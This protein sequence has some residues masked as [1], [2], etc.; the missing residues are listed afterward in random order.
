MPKTANPGRVA[1]VTLLLL[2]LAP[3][4]CA[5]AGENEPPASV[6]AE[7]AG[8]EAPS[9]G[10]A[11]AQA[12]APAASDTLHLRMDQVRRSLQA[13]RAMMETMLADTVRYAPI[14]EAFDSLAEAGTDAMWGRFGEAVARFPEL[15][16]A[17]E[18]EGVE[19]A[20]ML[21]T[22]MAVLSAFFASTELGDA[23]LGALTPEQRQH[24][25]FVREHNEELERL[26]STIPDPE[27]M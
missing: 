11:G 25:E 20:E 7:T 19:P 16:E 24:V 3:A 23:E 17:I 6:A 5:D 10:E 18:A 1:G 27:G 21:R 9:A 26:I 2:M 15:E 13:Y 14:G 12:A 8:E 4:A 22:T